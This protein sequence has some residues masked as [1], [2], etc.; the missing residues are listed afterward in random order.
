MI[1]LDFQSRVHDWMLACFGEEI[2]TDEIERNH[3]FLEESLELVQSL[4]CSKSEAHQL[5]DYVY[6]RTSGDP[7]QE[8]GGVMVT[9]AALCNARRMSSSSNGDKELARVWDK[10]HQ[11]REKQAAKPKHS[12]LSLHWSNPGTGLVNELEREI[13]RLNREL[14]DPFD[15]AIPTLK[16]YINAWM[17]EIG[18]YINRKSHQIDGFVLRTRDALAEARQEGR[19]EALDAYQKSLDVPVL[20]DFL[21]GAVIEAQHQRKRHGDQHDT[22]KTPEQW[23]WVG[24]ALCQWRIFTCLIF[25]A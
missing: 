21:K 10:I 15:G 19:K 13:I 18:G 20:E 7:N 6:S 2:A 24:P 25:E 11:I 17:R 22:S 14:H 16:M 12:P 8:C 23:Y 1:G 5:V 9:L 3:R 4:G